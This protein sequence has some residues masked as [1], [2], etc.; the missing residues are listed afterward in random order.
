MNI[1][2]TGIIGLLI[3]VPVAVLVM[4]VVISVTCASCNAAPVGL[5]VRWMRALLGCDYKNKISEVSER[6]RAS[7]NTTTGADR[8]IER[9]G[10]GRSEC[11]GQG[12]CSMSLAVASTFA[13]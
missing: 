8:D 9:E 11:V 6:S 5:V 3:L 13:F 12:R 7:P 1:K 4:V 2:H 10:D